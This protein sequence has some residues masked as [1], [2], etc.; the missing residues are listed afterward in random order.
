MN[1][2][3][4]IEV[5]NIELKPVTKEELEKFRSKK[6]EH[7]MTLERDCMY[8]KSNF[9]DVWDNFCFGL[10]VCIVC[11]LCLFYLTYLKWSSSS[12]AIFFET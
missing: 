1:E 5:E 12:L 11:L 2:E 10:I 4:E 6:I 9:L 7:I 3:C 8:K